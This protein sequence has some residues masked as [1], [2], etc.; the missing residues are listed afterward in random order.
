MFVSF[1]WFN[2]Q[3]KNSCFRHDHKKSALSLNRNIISA[4]R[5][6]WKDA[7]TMTMTFSHANGRFHHW[8]HFQ[9]EKSKHVDWARNRSKKHLSCILLLLK[10]PRMFRKR[11]QDTTGC[12]TSWF[13]VMTSYHTT[14][15]HIFIHDVCVLES[16]EVWYQEIIFLIG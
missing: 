16:K 3:N 12:K 13:S 11:Q 6:Y 5:K 14:R 8:K 9:L 15:L 7:N 10:F 2:L 4:R 1:V